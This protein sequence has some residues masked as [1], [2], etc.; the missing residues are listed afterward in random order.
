MTSAAPTRWEFFPVASFDEHRADRDALNDMETRS[1]VLDSRFVACALRNFSSGHE[2]LAVATNSDG[3]AG[4][5]ILKK[6]RPFTWTTFQPSQAPLGAFITAKR[7]TLASLCED[8]VAQLPG[9]VLILGVVTQ[10]DPDL[11]E[12]PVPD[13]RSFA[14]HYIDTA[15]VTKNDSFDA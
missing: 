8:L 2:K 9:F 4:A 1:P 14:F 3:I 13:Q 12:T 7:V 15:R 11:A 6:A 5:A 10:Q